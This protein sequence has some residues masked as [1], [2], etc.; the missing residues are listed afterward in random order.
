MG[1]VNVVIV[2]DDGDDEGEDDVESEDGICVVDACGG[3]GIVGVRG[4]VRIQHSSIP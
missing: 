1:I 3:G 2:E 4:S